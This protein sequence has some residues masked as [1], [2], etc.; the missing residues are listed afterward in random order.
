M[1]QCD[2][3]SASATVEVLQRK[4]CKCCKCKDNLGSFW[5]HFGPFGGHFGSFG[6]IWGSFGRGSFGDHLGV[7]W[8][9]LGVIWGPCGDHLG[10]CWGHLAAFGFRQ[11]PQEHPGA[12]L[13]Y[14]GHQKG[15]PKDL[16][17]R[18]KSLFFM[19]VS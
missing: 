11:A 16:L 7:I 10:T 5:G 2:C 1:L 19:I 18:P 12:L 3:C 14:L 6:I 9:H 4:Q 15:S 13:D 8:G 17:W